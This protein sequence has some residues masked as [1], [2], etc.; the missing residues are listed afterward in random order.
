VLR[1][2]VQKTIPIRI[3]ED[4][5]VS[6]GKMKIHPRETYSDVIERLINSAYKPLDVAEKKK[7][8]K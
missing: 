7:V 2:S 3:R 4:L 6:L 8:Q 1:L 5:V